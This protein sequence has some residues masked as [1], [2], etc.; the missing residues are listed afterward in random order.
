MNTHQSRVV[1]A[2]RR[3]QQWAVGNPGLVP[4][5][6]GAPDTWSVL[7]RTL[8]G[9]NGVVTRVTD[10]VA[11]Q[12]TQAQ[13]ATLLSKDE[14][15]LRQDLRVRMR[16]ITKIA[17]A[18]RGTVPGIGQLKMPKSGLRSEAVA[19]AANTMVKSAAPYLSVL[20]EHG[21]PQDVLKQ[22]GDAAVALVQSIDG[23]GQAQTLRAGAT[24][25]LET[26]LALGRRFVKVMGAALEPVL[27]KTPAK[28]AEWQHAKRITV[29]GVNSGGSAP[30][31]PAAVNVP[32]SAPPATVTPEPA[33]AQAT[34]LK[35]A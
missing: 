31:T 23:R 1:Q 12:G 19:N 8:D 14:P 35:V 4:P 34:A 21:Q 25:N 15:Q 30:A 2:L 26:D 20:V 5:P 13:Q 24:K 3:V 17:Q 10:S 33:Q 27:R 11:E 18:Q 29:K 7:T 16:D 22:L 28:L 32:P 6:V 9:L